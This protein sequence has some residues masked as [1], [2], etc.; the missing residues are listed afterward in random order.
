MNSSSGLSLVV[1][2][3]RVVAGNA[4]C[5]GGWMNSAFKYV[6]ENGGIDYEQEYPYIAKVSRRKT[7]MNVK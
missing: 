5:G 2:C 6:R 7:S 3:D 4:G 1:I